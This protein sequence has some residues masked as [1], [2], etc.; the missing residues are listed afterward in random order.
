ML[1]WD[2]AII[3]FYTSNIERRL[4]ISQ[5]FKLLDITNDGMTL[6]EIFHH[7]DELHRLRNLSL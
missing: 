7:S 4:V 2:V 6:Q 5:Y 3:I 1:P